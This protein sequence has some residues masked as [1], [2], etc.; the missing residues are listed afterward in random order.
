MNTSIIVLT[1][2]DNVSQ[3]IGI[4][5]TLLIPEDLRKR[6][7]RISIR[8]YIVADSTTIDDLA[9]FFAAQTSD[10]VIV[11][12]DNRLGRFVKDLA[13]PLFTIIFDYDLGGKSL[14]NY[15][16]MILSK[17]IK[18][19]AAF[20][21][22]FDNEK[23]RKLLILPLRNFSADGLRQLHGLFKDGVTADGKFINE[24]D[25]LLKALRQRQRPKNEANYSRT[26]IVD[27]NE[28]YFEYG[29]EK[30]SQ[31]ETGVPPHNRLCAVAGIFRF[32]KRYDRQRHFNLSLQ[33]QR[34]QGTFYD[35]HGQSAERRPTTHI[36]MF[37]NDFFGAN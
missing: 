21:P 23:L 1:P 26:Y 5:K 8:S 6:Y 19:F 14:Q 17:V 35:C 28:R 22:R 10:G 18:A 25:K 2:D 15:F 16:W 37:P 34:I 30:H 29:K 24:L 20:A 7:P 13:T 36:N 11:L 33:G 32:G 27:D 9:I 31:L 12:C 3:T 4:R